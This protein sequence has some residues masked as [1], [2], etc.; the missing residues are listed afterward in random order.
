MSEQRGRDW[1]VTVVVLLLCG[2]ILALFTDIETRA[3][4]W[5][6]PGARPSTDRSR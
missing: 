5:L 1:L 3:V 4:R 2:A 6:N